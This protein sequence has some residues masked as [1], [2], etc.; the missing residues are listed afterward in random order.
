MRYSK[1]CLLSGGGGGGDRRVYLSYDIPPKHL[2]AHHL[3]LPIYILP[4]CRGRGV[5][6]WGGEGGEG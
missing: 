2:S 1:S 3:Y 6:G 4:L 5:R